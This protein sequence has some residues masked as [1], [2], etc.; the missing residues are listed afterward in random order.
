MVSKWVSLDRM[1]APK[2]RVKIRWDP[3]A[4]KAKE[5]TQ[6]RTK[7]IEVYRIHTEGAVCRIAM[8]GLSATR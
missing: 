8:E 3:G 7:E 1:G 5:F 4:Q 6:C 2:C